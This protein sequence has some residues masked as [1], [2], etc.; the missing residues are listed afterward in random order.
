MERKA[1]RKVGSLF[2]EAYL[3]IL[4]EIERVRERAQASGVAGAGTERI[5]SQLHSVSA[6]PDAGL[7]PTNHEIM[8]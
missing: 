1:G 8:T 6:E 4:V 5:L 2:L 7:E 3:F